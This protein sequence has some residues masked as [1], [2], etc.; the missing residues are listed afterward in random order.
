[1]QGL[2]EPGQGQGIHKLV[3]EAKDIIEGY[4]TVDCY[5]KILRSPAFMKTVYAVAHSCSVKC[6][7]QKNSIL[8]LIKRRSGKEATFT[9]LL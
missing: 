8:L 6:S 4:S 5:V 9:I 3:L 1:M 7:T 2:G